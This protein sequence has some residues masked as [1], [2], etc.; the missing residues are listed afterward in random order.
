MSKMPIFLE[1]LGNGMVKS[2]PG[3]L[4]AELEI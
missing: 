4:Q 2:G 1:V 3:S